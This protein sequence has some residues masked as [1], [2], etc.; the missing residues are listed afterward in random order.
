MW[1]FEAVEL[2]EAADTVVEA[3]NCGHIGNSQ[4]HNMTNRRHQ[5]RNPMVL[6][7]RRGSNRLNYKKL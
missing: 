6:L 7:T 4:Y 5:N 3:H 1:V 2:V